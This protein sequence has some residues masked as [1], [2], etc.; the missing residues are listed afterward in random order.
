M[1]LQGTGRHLSGQ[2]VTTR[3]SPHQAME[4]GVGFE[5]RQGGKM[6]IPQEQ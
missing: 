3:P 5:T 6:L 2:T 1:C 4:N